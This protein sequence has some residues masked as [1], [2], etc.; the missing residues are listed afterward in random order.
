MDGLAK[1]GVVM[2]T[3]EIVFVSVHK[4]IR[5]DQGGRVIRDELFIL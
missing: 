5:E 3:P 2:T 1:L 4:S